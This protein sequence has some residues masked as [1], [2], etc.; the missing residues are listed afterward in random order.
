MK[1]IEKFLLKNKKKK[2]ILC[3]GVFDI[4]HIGHINYFREAKKL[5]DK[6]IVSI[7]CDK[8]VKKG[9]NRPKFNEKLR[10]KVLDN[11]KCIDLVIINKDI[12]P[13][14]II[15]KIKP[16]FYVKGS[17]YKVM[18]KDVTGNILLEKKA[19]ES[20]GGKIKFT[21]SKIY[22]SSEIINE[23]TLGRTLGQKKIINKI[24]KFSNSEDFLSLFNNLKKKKIILIGE[25]ILDKYIYCDVVGKSGKEPLLVSKKI[26]EKN[27]I[28]G[29]LSVANILSSFCKTVDLITYHG[30]RNINKKKLNKN[31]ILHSFKKKNSPTITKSRYIDN[32]Q[33]TKLFAVY[34]I[35][36][37]P[38]DENL[39]KKIISLINKLK[40]NSDGLF[41]I[42]YGHG[43]LTTK[44]VN[45]INKLK[46][47]KSLNVQ[48][49][50]FNQNFQ[51]ISKY[52]NIN[53]GCFN[54]KELSNE[55]KLKDEKLIFNSL[56]KFI[57][58]LNFNKMSVTLGSDGSNIIDKKGT[59]NFC[60]SFVQKTYDRIGAGD[61]FFSISS[62]L[63][64][65][66]MD[67]AFIQLF[68]SYLSGYALNRDGPIQNLNKEEVLKNFL[69]FIK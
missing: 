2:I 54:I 13:I 56:S 24:K 34:D 64:L 41:I 62:L 47:F 25:S 29:A 22:S 18:K 21:K 53:Y 48:Y 14:N 46:I 45:V 39:T 6:L 17:D 12:T 1:E 20:V 26:K 63:A 33:K 61:C 57:R 16:F 68:S 66:N 10:K 8:Y 9:D 31:V 36:D 43:L 28:G 3:H 5:G 52:K 37:N 30:D 49:N 59:G 40:T 65:T 27:M 7:T 60:P 51:S 35:E 58:K 19:V 69:Y 11:L 50:A 15:K 42:D 32:Y 4:L 55:L 67:N 38:V 44:I 23:Q